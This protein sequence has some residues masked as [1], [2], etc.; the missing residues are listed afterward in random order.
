MRHGETRPPR[1]GPNPPIWPAM[2][3]AAAAVVVGLGVFY[4]LLP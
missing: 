3:A 1:P 2:L 4:L